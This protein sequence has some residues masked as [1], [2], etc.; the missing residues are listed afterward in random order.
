M[1]FTG[2]LT[3]SISTNLFFKYTN[4]YTYR[5]HIHTEVNS[6][7]ALWESQVSMTPQ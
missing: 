5:T 4:M 1:A 2:G 3:G 7:P 6:S